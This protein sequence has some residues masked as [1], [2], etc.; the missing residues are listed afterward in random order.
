VSISQRE[1][2]AALAIIGS[3]S[4]L[5]TLAYAVN[6]E[7]APDESSHIRVVE[8]HSRTLRLS[9][10]EKW[11]YGDFRG[12]PY[13]LFSPVPYAVYVPFH[14]MRELVDQ[15]EGG[16]SGVEVLR[17]GGVVFA[18]LQ[19]LITWKIAIR[20]FGQT[21]AAGFA[22]LAAN[23]VPQLRYVHGYVNAD[24]FAILLGAV[25]FYWIL[26][27]FDNGE[28][29]LL[30]S[31]LV[32]L[33]LAAM[34]HGKYTVF[35]I[36]GLLFLVFAIR[37]AT[38]RPPWRAAYRLVGVPLPSRSFSRDGFTCTSTRSSAMERSWSAEAS[39]S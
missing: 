28:P 27:L 36:A 12:H 14:W 26:R 29:T 34:A 33:T 24:A 5:V 10:W 21:W 16:E 2:V 3:L 19:V 31:S 35:P 25:A 17:L 20:L 11:R 30:T 4:V 22:T 32:G 38:V 1:T 18:I 15:G 23:L 39:S 37:V 7:Y 9:T 6:V 13:H 8:H